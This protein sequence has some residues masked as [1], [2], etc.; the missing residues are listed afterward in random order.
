LANSQASSIVSP[1]N[2]FWVGSL[3][4]CKELSGNDE[5]KSEYDVDKTSYDE[6]ENRYDR[7][8]PKATDAL[9]FFGV[10]VVASEVGIQTFRRGCAPCVAL[11]LTPE[12]EPSHTH[13]PIVGSVLHRP[14]LTEVVAQG[15]RLDARQTPYEL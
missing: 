8:N 12:C 6:H 11:T 10:I 4:C 14:L 7:K 5:D 1:A 13:L 15:M 9:I 2:G 3:E